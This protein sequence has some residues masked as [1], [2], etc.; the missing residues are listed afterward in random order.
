[1]NDHGM[2]EQSAPLKQLAAKPLLDRLKEYSKSDVEGVLRGL[3]VT[4]EMADYDD[5]MVNRVRDAADLCVAVRELLRQW[6]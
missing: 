1:M 6:P 2:Q 3:V 4:G 5:E